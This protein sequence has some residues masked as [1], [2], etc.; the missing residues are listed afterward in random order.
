MNSEA[1]RIISIRLSQ[2]HEHSAAAMLCGKIHGELHRNSTSPIYNIDELYVQALS[3]PII[4]TSRSTRKSSQS[5][6]YIFLSGQI[7]LQIW[8]EF[9]RR[10]YANQERPIE[11]PVIYYPKPSKERQNE[12][13]YYE[14]FLRPFSCQ[15]SK[16]DFAL[17]YHEHDDIPDIMRPASNGATAELYGSQTKFL[18]HGGLTRNTLHLYRKSLTKPSLETVAQFEGESVEE[19]LHNSLDNLTRTTIDKGA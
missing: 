3:C 4:V 1:P 14:T 17:L 7:T 2:L 16:S 19:Q 6:K 8:L 18:Q 11:L 5:E 9:E 15:I 12:L 13:A 10:P